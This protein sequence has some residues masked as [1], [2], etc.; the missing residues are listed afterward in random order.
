MPNHPPVKARC[1]LREKAERRLLENPGRRLDAPG[2]GMEELLRELSL[3]RIERELQEEEL[4]AERRLRASEKMEALALMAGGVAHDFSNV[5]GAMMGFAELAKDRAVKESR[6]EHH[7]RRVLEAG[8]R[9]RE[10]IGRLLAFSTKKG[11]RLKPLRLSGLV[12]ETIELLRPSIPPAV[13]LRLDIDPESGLVL[14]D[15]GQMQQVLTHLCMNAVQ[16]MG[17]EGGILR[18]AL[19]GV[20]FTAEE[21]SDAPKP[22][23]CVRL[24]VSDTGCGM[25]SDIVEKVFDPFFTT[26]MSAAGLGL[27]AVWGI[28]RQHGGRIEVESAPGK[29]AVFKVCLPGAAQSPEADAADRT[30]SGGRAVRAVLKDK[31]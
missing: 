4:L 18:V 23:A 28:V 30:V 8:E 27:S 24:L 25:P 11:V 21:N 15:A 10:L 20:G 29:G 12:V 1:A 9:G 2:Q 5:L 19:S 6:Q 17:E 13:A 7:L 16:A 22:D 14:A 31:K 3:L 26:K